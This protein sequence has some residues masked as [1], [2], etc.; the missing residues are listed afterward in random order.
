MSD[1]RASTARKRRMKPILS[2]KTMR[3]ANSASLPGQVIHLS[4]D[5]TTLGTPMRSLKEVL[6]S[7]QNSSLSSVVTPKQ[8]HYSESSPKEGNA[9]FPTTTPLSFPTPPVQ[10]VKSGGVPSSLSTEIKT[11]WTTTSHPRDVPLNVESLASYLTLT[12]EE[13]EAGIC[14]Y[15][16]LQN[17]DC[18]TQAKLAYL[19]LIRDAMNAV[20]WQ[21][22]HRTALLFWL[23]LPDPDLGGDTPKRRVIAGSVERILFIEKATAEGGYL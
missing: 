12:P 17:I 18:D 8:G 10:T 1:T 21:L 13:I 3:R 7:R 23:T 5:G 14:A 20:W 16:A 22:G 15:A 4:A 19:T 11:E 2:I 9:S 6:S